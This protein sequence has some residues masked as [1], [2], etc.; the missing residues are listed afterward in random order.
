[1]GGSPVIVGIAGS[2]RKGS[3]N[4]ALLR[5]A[6][7]LSPPGARIESVSIRGVPLYDGDVEAERG[8]PEA[9]RELKD[10]IAESAGLII[11]TPEYNNSIPGVLKN[12]IDWLS[13]PASDIPRVF[14]GR[15]VSLMGASPGR[16]GT[17][18]SQT[19]W[20]PVLRALGMRPWWGPRLL[21]G[22]AN[23]VFDESGRLVDDRIRTQLR[24][25]M[26]GFVE[27]AVGKAT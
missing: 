14:G 8:I 17:V 9:V 19:A 16:F 27:F 24:E 1:M 21:V 7:E 26:A 25:Y 23:K 15:A 13:R 3:Y 11:V 2:V 20:L 5:A 22:G 4:A 18:M 6:I 10:K 12:A